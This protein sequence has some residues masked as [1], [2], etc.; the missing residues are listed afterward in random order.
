M[1]TQENRTIKLTTPLGEN[2][3]ILISL[4]GR[5]AVSELFNFELGVVW[6]KPAPLKFADI[7]GKTVTI[8]IDDER[9]PRYINGIVYAIEQG[10]Y[11]RVRDLT[12]YT[13][14]VAPNT[15]SLTRNVQS[16][17]FQ[18][19]SVPDIVKEVISN[20]GLSATFKNSLQGTYKPRD[21][22]VQYRESDFAFI[23]RLMES[24]GIF[25]FYQH[26]STQH[27][28]VIADKGTTFQDVPSGAEIEF[29]EAEGGQLEKSRIYSWVKVQKKNESKRWRNPADWPACAFSISDPGRRFLLSSP[30]PTL[31]WSC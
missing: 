6:Q 15:W 3:L 1:F 12:Y 4:R 21:Y 20:M 27:T 16:H 18:Q 28:L 7:L 26:D 14:H 8:E 11:D 24:E 31:A 29:E 19:K 5:E 22:C 9:P 2:A 10:T 25:Y 23:S 17:I 13:L 30:L